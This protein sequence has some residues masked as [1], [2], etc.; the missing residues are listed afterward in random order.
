VV[1]DKTGTVTVGRP[2][3]TDIVPFNGFD[4]QTILRAAASVEKKSEHPV[5]RAV[6]ES[7]LSRGI[8]LQEAESFRSMSGF[9]VLGAVDGHMVVA[10]NASLLENY[11]VSIDGAEETVARLSEEGKSLVF[12]ALD[13]RLAGIIGIADT[14]R[15]S[16][17]DAV[18]RLHRMNIE[19]VL[20][21]GDNDR[22]ARAIAVQ[23]GVD[24]VF[25]QVLPGEKANRI[26]SIQ[27]AG[28]I[29]AMVG[30]GVNDAPAL[31]QADVGIAI[32]MGADVAVETADITL[33]RGDPLDVVRAIRLS[34]RTME[35]IRQNLFWAFIYN[36]VGIPVAAFG[37]LNPMI[38]AAAMAFSSVSVVT[39]SLRLKNFRG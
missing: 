18:R 29:V 25:A 3:V 33:M 22:T 27:A 37:L 19:V 26:R 8:A 28:K 38:A 23:A 36:S 32:G 34:S 35:T 5:G 21:T 12:V 10:G 39:N 14:I 15:E 17:A 31:A 24:R 20:L 16:A 13:G 2:N 11:S 4:E 6:V 1:L 30:D 7:A 9:G